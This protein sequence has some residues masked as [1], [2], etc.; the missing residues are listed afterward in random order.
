MFKLS[1]S[2]NSADLLPIEEVCNQLWMFGYSGV[3]LSFQRGQFD[4]QN[5]TPERIAELTQFFKTSPIRPVCISTATTKFLSEVPHEPSLINH[6]PES[7]AKRFD[8]IL[9]GIKLAEEINIPLVS[10]Q[11]GYIRDEQ[12]HLSHTQIM[13]ILSTEIK[14]LLTHIKKNVRLVLEPEP[15]MFIETIE[16]AHELI[17]LVN[18]QRFGLHLDIGHVFCSEKDYIKAIRT[19]GK[20]TLYMHMADIKEGF[21]LK[22]STCSLSEASDLLLMEHPVNQATLFDIEDKGA[23]LF[24]TE[25]DRFMLEYN[26]GE[27][28][29]ELNIPYSQVITINDLDIQSKMTQELNLELLAYLDSVAG[30]SYERALRAYN[31]VAALRLGHNENQPL[32]QH[33]VCNTL[34]GKVHYHDLFGHGSIDYPAVLSALIDSGFD[35]YCTVELYNH[36]PLWRTIAPQSLKYLLAAMT[37]HYGWDEGDFGHIDHTTISAPYI[38]VAD[39]QIGPNGDTSILYDLRLC[40]PNTTALPSTTLHSLEHSLLAILPQVLPGFLMVAPMG[41]RTGLYITTAFPLH[42]NYVTAQLLTALK[43]LC[44]LNTVPY[45]SEKSCGMAHDHDLKAAQAIAAELL[46][47]LPT[48]KVQKNLCDID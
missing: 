5:I 9:M 30:V 16:E 26:A 6:D 31:A 1:Y 10:F 32:I 41:C 45:Q 11:S 22:F 24:I 44:K 7:R 4:P 8:L 19:H 34:R 35:G 42:K 39:S 20:H 21:N 17:S 14:N 15:G 25:N 3:E 18:D 23:F 2:C 28:S 13:S 37:N 12:S 46:Q 38:R 33:V 27:Y 29:K 43:M 48:S 36:A 47:K 40:E